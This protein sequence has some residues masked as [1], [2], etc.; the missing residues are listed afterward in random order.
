MILL[1]CAVCTSTVI[2][3]KVQPVPERTECGS[4]SAASDVYTIQACGSPYHATP[5]GSSFSVLHFMRTCAYKHIS[6]RMWARSGV[7]SLAGTTKANSV[8][9]GHQ[10][11]AVRRYGGQ[12]AP[13]NSHAVLMFSSVGS[14]TGWCAS[15]WFEA[16]QVA[17]GVCVC[18]PRATHQHVSWIAANCSQ[19]SKASSCNF[20]LPC[21]CL[22][23]CSAT[24]M[25]P[26]PAQVVR[27]VCGLC[28]RFAVRPEEGL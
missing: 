20:M 9:Q 1:S 19:S 13:R 21:I 2:L 11:A 10:R 27:R 25:P 18:A 17:A 14:L 23:L 22:Q 26:L 4:S 8:G 28:S 24:P 15:C 16:L 3:G 6:V 5:L 7:A 12:A